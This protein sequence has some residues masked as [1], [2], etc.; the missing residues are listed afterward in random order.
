MLRKYGGF[1]VF[2]VL[3]GWAGAVQSAEKEQKLAMVNV[4]FVFEKYRRVA[5]ADRR[6]D[7]IFAAERD[8]LAKRAEDIKKRHKAVEDFFNAAN[9]SDEVF[10]EV[11]KLRKDQYFYEKDVARLNMQI[12]KAYAREMREVLG[13]IR[14]SIR[15][16]AEKGG[17]DVVLRSPDSDDP[18]TAE[19]D[20]RRDP[21][22]AD[23]ATVLQR[24]DPRTVAQV[25]ERFNRNPVLFGARAVDI[26]DLVLKKLNDDFDR[27][28]GV[29]GK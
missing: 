8:A 23:K 6:I 21:A 4:S 5:D 15:T 16:V 19:I 22:A 29:G 24:M 26:T 17:F 27:R 2:L 1:I 10:N 3:A 28:A 14:V 13:E 20:T 18:V 7:E 9:Q 12:Q 25:L 11:Q